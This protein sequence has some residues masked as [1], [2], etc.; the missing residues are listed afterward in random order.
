ML[1]PPPSLSAVAGGGSIGG[2]CY[3]RE[4]TVVLRVKETCGVKV[5]AGHSG[6]VA[7][8]VP[9]SVPFRVAIKTRSCKGKIITSYYQNTDKI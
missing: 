4:T 1:P 8:H 2:V 9:V 6:R 5:T 3:C 7:I